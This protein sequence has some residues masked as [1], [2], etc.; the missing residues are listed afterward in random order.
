MTR[1]IANPLVVLLMCVASAT[2]QERARVADEPPVPSAVPSTSAGMAA[3]QQAAAARKFA[4][5]FFW[6]EK[7]AATERAWAVVQSAA[8]KVPD[9]ATVAAVQVTNPAEKELVTRYDLTRTPMPFVLVIAPCGAITKALSGAFTEAQLHTALVSPCTQL[10]LK[11][12]QDRK[13]VLLCVLDRQHARERDT[14]PRA[15]RDFK[16]DA[17]FEAATEIVLLDAEDA[18]E[19]GF[20][21]QLK[22]D[23]RAPRPLTVLL[24]P[25][26]SVV[27]TFGAKATKEQLV[28]QLA[29]AQSNPCAGGKCGPNGCGPKK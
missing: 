4:F 14:L 6:K 5:M 20:L 24:A 9:V 26:G 17:R 23:P 3:I 13:L 25:P 19:A 11:A 10:C 16:A 8:V 28:A 29:A 22:V 27:G 2:G 1:T 15:A 7:D 21:E 12:I 18:G